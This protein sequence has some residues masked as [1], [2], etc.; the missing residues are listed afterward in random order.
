MTLLFPSFTEAELNSAELEDIEARDRAR[1]E[2]SRYNRRF[3]GEPREVSC[4][5]RADAGAGR[6]R[7]TGLATGVDRGRRDYW[8]LI[9]RGS[10]A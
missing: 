6:I 3:S 10:V 9:G 8:L 1:T 7:E 4:R 2:S 5:T